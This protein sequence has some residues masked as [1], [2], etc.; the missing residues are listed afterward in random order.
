MHPRRRRNSERL[1]LKSPPSMNNN[2]DTDALWCRLALVLAVSRLLRT[3]TMPSHR[4]G[5]RQ[6]RIINN[7]LEIRSCVCV[8]V[9]V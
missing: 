4:L 2:P 8:C 1:S 3:N 5:D 7:W 6:G 9:C